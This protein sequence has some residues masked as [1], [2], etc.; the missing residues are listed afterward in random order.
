[1]KKNLIK[2]TFLIAIV[3]LAI[4]GFS[5]KVQASTSYNSEISYN[6]NYNGTVTVVA[7]GKT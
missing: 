6:D 1:M 4:L 5:T 7:A 2:L 3:M